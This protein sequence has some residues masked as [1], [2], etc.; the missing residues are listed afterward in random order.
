M[1]LI[2]VT[3]EHSNI[4]L[5]WRNHP[6]IY[7]HLFSPFP[8]TK[9]DHEKWFKGMLT[10]DDI[11]F[12]IAKVKNDYVGAIRLDKQEHKIIEVGIYVDPGRQGQGH[13]SKMLQ[14]AEERLKGTG[15]WKLKA[16]VKMQNTGSLKLFEKNDF[17]KDH[18][19]FYKEV[20]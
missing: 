13:A 2:E 19:V 20:E 17:I 15:I 1:E 4:I 11:T 12:Y 5:S 18:V 7:K 14:L 16:R 8:V 3:E 9:D 6:E 10:N